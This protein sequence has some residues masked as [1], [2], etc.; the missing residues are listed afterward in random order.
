MMLVIG[1]IAQAISFVWWQV[2][3]DCFYPKPRKI[4]NFE[5]IYAKICHFAV[6]PQI[7]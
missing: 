1:E 5:P 3:Q 2:R 4:L 7:E 6:F